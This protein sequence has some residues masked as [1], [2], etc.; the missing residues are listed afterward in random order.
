[1]PLTPTTAM[2]PHASA[3]GGPFDTSYARLPQRLYARLTPTPVRRPHLVK[4]N[5]ALA[6]ALGLKA[7]WLASAEGTAVLAGNHVPAWADPLAMAY[8]G[9][10]FGHF[11][12][13][14]GDGRAI[15]LGE[16]L[17]RDGT[18]R[19]LQLKGAGRTPFSRRG[20][21][22]AALGPVLREYLLSEAMHAL[23]IPTTRALAVVTTG[24]PV[25]RETVLPG[26]VLAKPKHGFT[27]PISRWLGAELRD[28]AENLLFEPRAEQRGWF[29]PRTVKQLW[30]DHHEGVRDASHQLWLLLVLELWCRAFVDRRPEASS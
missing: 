16:I 3:Y 18:R 17:G 15:L 22:R 28:M 6:E 9:H 21:G 14:L 29:N 30:A 26:A 1:M 8:A 13:Q 25:V 20:D 5:A 7:M 27:A 12:P 4:L 2:P 23:G 24:E 11:V 19:D 10:Q